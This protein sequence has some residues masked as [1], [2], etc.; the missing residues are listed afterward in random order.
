[1]KGD[2]MNRTQRLSSKL[3]QANVDINL[4]DDE[5]KSR[6]EL[7]LHLTR[8]ITDLS[9][10]ELQDELKWLEEESH[11]MGFAETTSTSPERK[12]S[13]EVQVR[14][15]RSDIEFVISRQRRQEERMNAELSIGPGDRCITCDRVSKAIEPR[16]PTPPPAGTSEVSHLVRQ[17][18]QIIV[19]GELQKWSKKLID[20]SFVGDIEEVRECI[21]WGMLRFPDPIED[22]KDLLVEL[23]THLRSRKDRLVD[24][25]RDIDKDGSGGITLEEL[26]DGLARR[27]LRYSRRQANVLMRFL[28]S[29][30]DGQIDYRE[31]TFARKSLSSS[32]LDTIPTATHAM[33]GL[34]I[35]E[36]RSTSQ[37]RS[38]LAAR[39]FWWTPKRPPTKTW[40]D[41]EDHI[42]NPEGC[43]CEFCRP[44]LASTTSDESH[45]AIIPNPL[46]STA[47]TCPCRHC[48]PK[49]R[50]R[51]N[52]QKNTKDSIIDPE[53]TLADYLDMPEFTTICNMS[54]PRSALQW[55][56]LKGHKDVVTALVCNGGA[57]VDIPDILSGM[58][59][60]HNA[61]VRGH[62]EIAEILIAHGADPNDQDP[63]GCTAGYMAASYGNAEL[64]KRMYHHGWDPYIPNDSNWS[65]LHAAASAGYS[66]CLVMLMN[67]G[68]KI[69]SVTLNA[70]TPLHLAVTGDHVPCEAL[71][72]EQ[73][74][75]KS[76]IFFWKDNSDRTALDLARDTNKINSVI[77]LEKQLAFLQD[78]L[79]PHP[80]RYPL[81]AAAY[82]GDD[83]KVRAILSD[84]N[85][86]NELVLLQ[87][88]GG[89]TALHK[90]GGNGKLRCIEVLMRY[91]RVKQKRIRNFKAQTAYDTAIAYSQFRA[92]RLI[93]PNDEYSDPFEDFNFADVG[94]T[95]ATALLEESDGEIE[96]QDIMIER[97]FDLFGRYDMIRKTFREHGGELPGDEEHRNHLRLL[98]DLISRSNDRVRETL[99]SIEKEKANMDSAKEAILKMVIKGRMQV[100]KELKGILGM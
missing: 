39:S 58:M 89:S 12:F 61:A 48:R 20:A 25:F 100:D 93:G 82:A 71:L 95:E 8:K 63:T 54:E 55:A 5:V 80:G 32:G 74:A 24:F 36:I 72:L 70:E 62:T 26:I 41:A 50:R 1:M 17:A 87:D 98:D 75:D 27:G 40:K 2:D 79:P 66:N 42:Y 83:E 3:Q 94:E 37:P 29:D 64:L 76:R 11:N 67:F 60:L 28:D 33:Q 96:V 99:I 65:P 78:I 47:N 68:S 86:P 9:G 88:N 19:W 52:M 85:D 84:A 16:P 6:D 77:Y 97:Y 56:A 21:A 10:S 73:A 51:Y 34:Q 57:T 31:M 23:E 46:D 81:H 91:S 69:D 35:E 45:I 30:G 7:K 49:S 22:A 59:P 4:T 44:V 53:F 90:A 14:R 13:N 15:R 92:A 43:D 18:R 38:A